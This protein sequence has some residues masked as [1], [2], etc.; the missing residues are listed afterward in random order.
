MKQKSVL[1]QVICVAIIGFVCILLTISLALLAGSVQKSIFDLK[2][3]NIG[4][5]IPVIII[6]VFVS[7][8]VVGIGVMF[9]SNS[10]F[11]KVSDY[12]KENKDNQN[13]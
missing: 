13:K 12:L 3:L 10:L 5:M 9:V 6:G 2:N 11:H 8:A 7:C 4:N 1:F